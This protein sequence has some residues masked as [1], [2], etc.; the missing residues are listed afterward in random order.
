MGHFSLVS[1]HITLPVDLNV[2]WPEEHFHVSKN[3]LENIQWVPFIFPSVF[4]I[5]A[6]YE[7]MAA[8]LKS[9]VCF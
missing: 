3:S 8:A 6:S 5:L 1:A 2:M 4:V 9:C 7:K